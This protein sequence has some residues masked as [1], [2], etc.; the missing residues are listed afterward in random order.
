[1]SETTS[2]IQC[3]VC[4][5]YA[6][7]R[8]PHPDAGKLPTLVKVGAV[9]ECVLCL[10]RARAGWSDRARKAEAELEKLPSS[11]AVQAA[12]EALGNAKYEILEYARDRNVDKVVSKINNAIAGLT[13]GEG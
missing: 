12:V 8:N 3:G 9:Y 7:V 4:G 6:M 11:E 13:G 10:C 1:M 2:K 5:E